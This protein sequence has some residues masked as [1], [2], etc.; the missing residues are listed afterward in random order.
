MKTAVILI[1]T[2]TPDDATVP[3][4]KR[5][6]REF[7][8]DGRV[9]SKPSIIRKL[10]VNGIIVPRRASKSAGLYQK[11]WTEKGS[12]L[13]WHSEN[14]KQ[15]LQK[16][17]GDDYD[18]MLAMRY[19]NPTLKNALQMV[20]AGNYREL[21]V[22]P[23]FPQYASSTVGSIMELIFK[24][25]HGWNN[26]PR[27]KSIHNFYDHPGYIN[28]V[29]ENIL[30][31]QKTFTPDHILFSFHG[32]P[33]AHV[34][35]THQNL[36]CEQFNCKEEVNQ[37]NAFCY[38][39]AS[40]ATAREIAYKLG[41]NSQDYSLAFQ[42]RFAKKWLEPFSDDLIRKMARKGIKNLLVVSPSFVADCL[43]TIEEI[44]DGFKQSFLKGGGEQFEWVESLNDNDKWVNVLKGMIKQMS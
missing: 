29:V 22:V 15:K 17:L 25:M 1:N 14:L 39:A 26:I 16:V 10:L 40:Y 19:G 5:Y 4:V 9:I 6:L 20:R 35:A 42:S 44:G 34:N 37:G 36:P 43:E 30:K 23:L 8:G 21:V 24:E 32:L 3:S 12:P 11:I 41:L 28:C 7:L 18:V 2:G 27:I 31:Q 38:Q 33:I 13:L